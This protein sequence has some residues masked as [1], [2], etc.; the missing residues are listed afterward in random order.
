[1][2]SREYATMAA[3]ETAFWWY[4]GQRSMILDVLASLPRPS[5][6]PVLD[7]GCGTGRL[8]VQTRERLG[9]TVVGIDRAPEA[10]TFWAEGGLACGSLASV[11]ALPFDDAT[12]SIVYS[13]DVLCCAEVDAEAAC[14]EFARVLRP[15][16][17]LVLV[18]PAYQWLL[19]EHDCA[20]H[21]TR[22]FDR[23]MLR[24]LL[25]SAGLVVRR[26]T[27]L[28]PSL[29]PAIAT[30]RLLRRR[31]DYNGHARSDL[32]PI[33]STLNRL[34]YGVTQIERGLLRHVDFPFG[35]TLLAVAAKEGPS[36]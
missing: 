11:N 17:H 1:M 16:G 22:R 20:V 14:A 6:G 18:V 24:T 28:F 3:F 33:P 30:V 4:R 8:A 31:S 12:F 5:D 10:S 29:F 7:A 2:E 23:R 15:G 9:A 27:N 32:R 21:A 26:V 35:T 25:V 13:V 34:L 19:S 36:R